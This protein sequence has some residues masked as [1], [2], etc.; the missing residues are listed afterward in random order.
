LGYEP[1]NQNADEP[2]KV[3][4]GGSWKDIAYYLETGTRSYEY[5][6]QKRSFIGFR[7]V[8]D[9]LEGRTASAR[10]GRVGAAARRAKAVK[11]RLR[12]SPPKPKNK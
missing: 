10:G 4:R 8:M 7:C 6:D 12:L 2:R 11:N 1:D 3:V 9:N 5:E